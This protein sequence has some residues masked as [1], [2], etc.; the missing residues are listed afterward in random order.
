[1]LWRLTGHRCTQDNY[2]TARELLQYDLSQ[3]KLAVLSACDTARDS[4]NLP[5]EGGLG[6]LRALL[7][8]GARNVVAS[9][10]KVDN[11]ETTRFFERFYTH[12]LAHEDGELHPVETLNRVQRQFI[13]EARS[14][15]D[16]SYGVFYWA[17][18][19]A[20]QASR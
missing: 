19:V 7:S 12:A 8:A 1:M 3:M 4:V 11:D 10:W 9:L 13:R 15:Y 6:V 18:F 20:F 16:K 17:P 2:L 14:S 5:G